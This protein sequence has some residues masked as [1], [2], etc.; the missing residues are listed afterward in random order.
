[1]L[2]KNIMDGK[3]GRGRSKEINLGIIKKLLS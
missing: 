3:R 1:M 2:I